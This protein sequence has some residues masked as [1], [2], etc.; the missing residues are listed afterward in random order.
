MIGLSMRFLLGV[1]MG[2][3]GGT[4]AL[5]DGFDER[6][7]ALNAEDWSVADY[8]FKHPYFDTDWSKAQVS[9]EDGLTLA[10]SAQEGRENRYVG[11]SVRRKEVTGFGRYEVVM[12]PVRGV[13][14]VT[15]FFTYTGPH[16]GT[17]HDEID[18]EFL[19]KN[20]RQIHL[21]L[22]V[23]GKLWNKFIDLGFDAADAPRAYAFEWDKDAV[24][25]YV[26]DEMIYERSVGDGPIPA[27]AGRLFAN[28]WAAD[29]AIKLWS[30]ETV[31]GTNGKAKVLRMRFVPE[32]DTL[33][34]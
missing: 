31:S 33:G 1:L 9:V 24:R 14:V 4:C 6:F 11:G 16:Y 28:V 22:F 12:Q 10:L 21:A 34:S 20:T 8:V 25:W 18:I 15:G 5:A 23:D 26:G 32:T 13:G 27:V 7:E 17:R 30:G 19:G 2:F 29:P 3:F